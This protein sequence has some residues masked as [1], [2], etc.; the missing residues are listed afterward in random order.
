MAYFSALRQSLLSCMSPAP[1]NTKKP[2]IEPRLDRRSMSPAARTKQWLATTSPPDHTSQTPASKTPAILGVK[3]SK[4]TK[5]GPTPSPSKKSQISKIFSSMFGDALAFANKPKDE[6]QEDFEGTTLIVDEAD[7]DPDLENDTTLLEDLDDDLAAEKA[8]RIAREEELTRTYFELEDLRAQRNKIIN[9]WAKG[10]R[11]GSEIGLFRKLQMVGLDPLLPLHWR[12]EFITYP[13]RIFT[14]IDKHA[15]IISHKVRDFRGGTPSKSFAQAK[16]QKTNPTIP[17]AIKALDRL[18][19]LGTRIRDQEAC[20][21][22]PE[23][24]MHREIALYQK[25]SEQDASFEYLSFIPAL[26]IVS[27]R[28]GETTQS[29]ANRIEKRLHAL[30]RRYRARNLVRRPSVACIDEEQNVCIEDA[31]E[32]EQCLQQLPTLYGIVITGSTVGFVSYDARVPGKKTQTVGLAHFN[33]EIQDVWNAL[34]VAIVVCWA[35]EIVQDI[36]PPWPSRT[37]SL[38]SDVDA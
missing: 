14:D 37:P 20:K 5:A 26:A 22:R 21:L 1:R 2:S 4:I 25:W 33:N 15:L 19:S 23:P 32:M 31:E 9:D 11:T 30:G 16:S 7:H 38:G 29:I 28:P 34:A 8:Q 6:P 17:L 13:L 27:A 35:R 12:F 36:C 24:L 3:G 18:T 10:N